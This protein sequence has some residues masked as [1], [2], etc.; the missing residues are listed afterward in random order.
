MLSMHILICLKCK[1]S[2][3][4]IAGLLMKISQ[5]IH[6]L[7]CLHLFMIKNCQYE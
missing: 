1:L 6:Q 4:K 7:K 3:M 2:F 5:A